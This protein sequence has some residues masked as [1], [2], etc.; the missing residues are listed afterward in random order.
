MHI[1]SWKKIIEKFHSWDRK[2]KCLTRH[3]MLLIFDHLR[4]MPLNQHCFR[5]VIDVG[6]LFSHSGVLV[7]KR[8]CSQDW[9][10]TRGQRV[11]YHQQFLLCLQLNNLKYRL[12]CLSFVSTLISFLRTYFRFSFSLYN[13]HCERIEMRRLELIKT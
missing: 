11:L 5:K 9:I 10:Y 6:W 3:T 12:Q 8:N 4:C 2:S 1:P 7:F 13:V